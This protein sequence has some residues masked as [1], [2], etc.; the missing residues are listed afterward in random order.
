[1]PDTGENTG[2]PTIHKT[3]FLPSKYM[4]W[5][6]IKTSGQLQDNVGRTEREACLGV[7]RAVRREGDLCLCLKRGLIR[8]GDFEQCENQFRE[9]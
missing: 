8:E 9:G 2:A 4:I 5:W 1:M 3:R 7:L 6:E